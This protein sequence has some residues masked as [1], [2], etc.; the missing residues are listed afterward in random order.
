ML[1][2]FTRNLGVDS[3]QTDEED[4]DYLQ[5]ELCEDEEDE[6]NNMSHGDQSRTLFAINSFIILIIYRRFGNCKIKSSL[7]AN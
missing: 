2:F 1:I 6:Y 5:T 7:G 3:R 4:D